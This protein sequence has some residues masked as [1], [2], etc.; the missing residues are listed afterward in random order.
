MAARHRCG[1]WIGSRTGTPAL[2]PC[3]PT[4]AVP[5]GAIPT[6]GETT[7]NLVPEVGQTCGTKRHPRPLRPLTLVSSPIP[8]SPGRGIMDRGRPLAPLVSF[9]NET[10]LGQRGPGRFLNAATPR[11]SPIGTRPREKPSRCACCQERG[12]SG[13]VPTSRPPQANGRREPAAGTFRG[14]DSRRLHK[15]PFAGIS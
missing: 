5:L 4:W 1:G 6:K 9:R 15:A 10:C 7:G 12:D 13:R 2:R 3:L 8:P 14:F 11:L